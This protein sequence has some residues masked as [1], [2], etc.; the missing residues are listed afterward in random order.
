MDGEKDRG[1][2]CPGVYR[3]CFVLPSA[4]ANAALIGFDIEPVRRLMRK[5]QQLHRQKDGEQQQQQGFRLTMGCGHGSWYRYLSA[6]IECYNISFI[7]K[8]KELGQ[9]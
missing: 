3:R 1:C 2:Y 4:Q 7:T 9:G 8:H 5:R 6:L